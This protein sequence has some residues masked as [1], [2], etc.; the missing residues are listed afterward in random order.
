MTNIRKR[1]LLLSDRTMRHKR[2]ET[3][4][5]W[6][7]CGRDKEKDNENRFLI[8]F[9][10]KNDVSTQTNMLLVTTK[11]WAARFPMPVSK[12]LDDNRSSTLAH[13]NTLQH[14]HV[15][16]LTAFMWTRRLWWTLWWNPVYVRASV[17]ILVHALGNTL[18]RH[19]FLKHMNS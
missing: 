16:I 12:T 8:A 7:I 5:N 9:C 1:Q 15:D 10:H 2:T 13:L 4:H 14:P 6:K 18:Y 3:C 17:H 11:C 19:T